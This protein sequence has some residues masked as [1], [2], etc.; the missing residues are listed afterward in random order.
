MSALFLP[1]SLGSLQLKNRIIIAPM[2]QY[3]A[4]DGNATDWHMVHLGG[5]AL[6]GAGLLIIEATAVEDIGRISPGDLGL[7]SD[8]NE[9]ALATV[10]TTLRKYSAMP[11]AIQLG[12]AGRKASS[13]AP[14]HGGQLIPLEEGGWQ[15]VAPSA[16]AHAQGER[17]PLAL[18]N[19]GLVRVK[20]A[21]VN[22]AKRA[23][24]LGIDAIELHAAHGYLLHQFLSP[25]SN[26]RTDQYGG[27]PENRMRFPLE[28]FDA[29]RTAIPE[30]MVVG[31]RIS[32]TDWVD[33]GLTI[34][35]S[36]QFALLLQEQGC[37]FIHVSSGGVSPLQQIPVGPGY[38]VHLANEL[39]QHCTLPVIA[40]GLI[41]EAQQAEEI[42]ATGQAD[43]IAIARG[44]LYDP[45]W[46]W[47]A[48]AKLGASVDAP[49]QYWRSQPRDQKNLF[50]DTKIGQR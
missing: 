19:D 15:M 8:D 5:L 24:R 9:A 45:H 7:W 25:L 31:I 28:V 43:A 44:I 18:D 36:K 41:T 29:V 26:Q 23:H 40:V 16:I 22:A 6:S 10:L 33:G 48:A 4:D 42:I 13:Q 46:P 12:H 35:Q 34:E 32:A 3:S 47:H 38:Q 50:G 1:L 49:H 37:D 11:V 30:K 17:A 20:A 14:W 27:S 2:C 21:F 39:K